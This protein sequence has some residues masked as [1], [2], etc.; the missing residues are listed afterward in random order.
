MRVLSDGWSVC[1]L[2]GVCGRRVRDW[3]RCA[4]AVVERERRGGGGEG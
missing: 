3:R 2:V 1:G 4:C